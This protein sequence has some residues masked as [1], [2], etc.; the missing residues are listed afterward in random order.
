MHRSIALVCVTAMVVSGAT[1]TA[2][3]LIT[4][5]NVKNNSLT[6]AD[7]KKGSIPLGDLTPATQ[8]LVRNGVLLPNNLPGATTP[9]GQG[10]AG[11][12]GAAGSN[13]AAGAAGADG[14]DGA[15]GTNGTN[16]ADSQAPRP[17]TAG[18]L[19]GFELLARGT[20]PDPSDNGVIEFVAGPA[21]PPL[22]ASSLRMFTQNGKNVSAIVPLREGND[23]PTISEL[24]TATY[25]AYVNTQP[26]PGLGV[27]LKLELLGTNAC[28]SGGAPGC[29]PSANGF[30]TLVYDP[31][32]NTGGPGENATIATDQWQRWNARGGTWFSSRPMGDGSCQNSPTTGCTIDDVIAATPGA[33]I[34]RA[35]LEIGQNSGAAWPG[36]DSNTDDVRLGFDGDFLRYDLGG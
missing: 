13:G 31:S 7:T 22:G 8:R 16:G 36:F 12:Q 10:E 3:S 24:T 15:D 27:T 14:A 33:T 26:Q 17:V 25:S 1:A 5:K 9:G 18:N 6:G 29:S 21:T 23:K 11:T 4:G 28:A 32:N 19:R 20:N 34:Q 30:T 2:A 35:R